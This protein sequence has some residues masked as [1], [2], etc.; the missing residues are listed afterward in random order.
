M[1]ADVIEKVNATLVKNKVASVV[2]PKIDDNT[3]VW[4]IWFEIY[5]IG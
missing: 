5:N 2:W 4:L 3:D 1:S